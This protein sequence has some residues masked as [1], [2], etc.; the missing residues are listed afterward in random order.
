MKINI[1]VWLIYVL[2]FASVGMVLLLFEL[3]PIIAMLGLI[4]TS[5]YLGF[6]LVLAQKE[7]YNEK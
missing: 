4:L 3:E 5:I 6:A 2:A 7:V 1:K